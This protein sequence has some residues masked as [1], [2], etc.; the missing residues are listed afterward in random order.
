MSAGSAVDAAAV[1]RELERNHAVFAAILR[2]PPEGLI[3]FRPAPGKWNL[4]E[5]VNHLADEE[6]DDF[7]TRVGL[8]LARATEPWP[9]IDPEGWVSDRD[10]ADRDYAAS[11]RGFLNE[12]LASLAWLKGLPDPDW[13]AASSHPRLGDMK[14]GVLLVNWLAHDYLHIRQVTALRYRFLATGMPPGSVDYAGNW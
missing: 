4:L 7:R 8:A 3:R 14:A 2:D 5:I 1:I 6:R 11:V 10:Y 12:R 13:A 9:P